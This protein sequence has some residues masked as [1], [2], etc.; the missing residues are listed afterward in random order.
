MEND[1]EVDSVL[2]NIS[3]TSS[4]IMSA[5]F[6]SARMSF[7][8][9]Q[10]VWRLAKKGMVAN[11]L[12]D[13]FLDFTQKTG[14]EFTVYNIPLSG[15]K[16]NIMMQLHDIELK[17]QNEKNPF[18]KPGIRNDIKKLEAKLPELDQLKKLGLS[19]CVLPKL[20]GSEQ[21]IQ[22]AIAKT[23]D[24]M[25]KN[26]FLNHL[27]TELRG[28]E[29]S[30]EG[31]KVFTEGNYTILNMP[32]EELE[33]LGVMMSDFN[34]MGVNYAILPD[35]SVGD[36]YTQIAVPNAD[37]GQIE[38]WFKFWK[39]KLLAN[40]VDEKDIKEMY[41]IGQ[42]SYANMAEISADEYINSAEQQFKD[43]QAEFEKES[44]PIPWEKKLAKE[45]S[46]EFVRL[47]QDDN[48]HKITI[49]KETLVV[50]HKGNAVTE[51]FEREFGYFT[52]RIPGTYGNR[53][54]TLVIPTDNVFVADDGKT[55]LA[56]ID[57]R[58]DYYFIK[59][60]ATS[61]KMDFESI[62]RI[63]DPVIRGF[64]HV[65]DLKQGKDLA[66]TVA[67]KVPVPTGPKL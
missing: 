17:L 25:F 9:L 3:K 23:D 1:R 38:Q 40:G 48:F 62:K 67:A 35:L 53:E 44:T 8:I 33:E 30:L 61:G 12:K 20:N 18:A 6:F 64:G 28:G 34:T 56:F 21:T 43:V 11:G 52:S 59:P 24:Q 60:D 63:Y 55:F 39:E 58:K 66:Q 15:D 50:N 45:N 36:G 32:F 2:M 26:W 29:K 51:R 16:A 22:V 54:Q 19:H 65:D 31:I 4:G 49:N 10:F 14:G 57:K 47:M 27:T 41:A 5:V 42:E 37:R 13:K 46:A 7:K